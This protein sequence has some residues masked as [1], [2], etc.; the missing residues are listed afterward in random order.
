MERRIAMVVIARI[1][2]DGQNRWL[3]RQRFFGFSK[4]QARIMFYDYLK[5]HGWRVVRD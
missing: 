4:K 5:E 2:T 1:V 3:E